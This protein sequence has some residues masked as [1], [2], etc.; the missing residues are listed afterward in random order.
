MSLQPADK[1]SLTILVAGVLAVVAVIAVATTL[2]VR[3]STEAE[4]RLSLASGRSL[5]QL[6]PTFLCDVKMESCHPRALSEAELAAQPPVDFPVPVGGTLTLSV[7]QDIASGPWL[8][9]ALYATPEGLQPVQ[10]FHLSGT[11]YTQVLESTADKT[12][13]LVE[14]KPASGVVI[15]APEGL[16]SGQGD[17]LFRGHY[18]ATT[19]PEGFV[20]PANP[21]ELPLVRG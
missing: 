4:P 18:A 21:T 6:E 20:A 12:L 3:G 2:L 9:T 8:L 5:L 7:P 10:W 15:D 1:K 11:T 13:L 17:I 19:A 16:E 14:V